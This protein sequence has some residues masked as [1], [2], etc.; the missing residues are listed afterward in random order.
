MM[1]GQKN[2][3]KSTYDPTYRALTAILINYIDNAGIYNT[4]KFYK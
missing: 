1:H 4:V 3:K 2:I